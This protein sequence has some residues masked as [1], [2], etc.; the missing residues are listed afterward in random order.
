MYQQPH[1]LK[2][3]ASYK[4]I[5]QSHHVCVNTRFLHDQ[6]RFTANLF[7]CYCYS[8]I[9]EYITYLDIDDYQ[10]LK[11]ALSINITIAN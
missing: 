7:N 11:Y 10:R 4:S 2:V 8:I 5:F 1:L 3:I 9:R 6:Y